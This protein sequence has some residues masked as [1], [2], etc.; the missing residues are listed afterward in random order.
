MKHSP[1]TAPELAPERPEVFRDAPP[2]DPELARLPLILS[3]E[4]LRPGEGH[5][6]RLYPQYDG[7]KGEALRV[8]LKIA[9]SFAMTMPVVG[10][11]P[12]IVGGPHARVPGGLFAEWKRI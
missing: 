3:S 9:A 11:V 4:P 7:W 6:F 2:P 10:C 5:G 12:T 8:D 1:I